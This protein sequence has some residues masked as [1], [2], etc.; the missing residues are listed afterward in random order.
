VTL[1]DDTDKI[2]LRGGLGIDFDTEDNR[3]L[4]TQDSPEYEQLLELLQG[5]SS[6]A[7]YHA[8][9]QKAVHSGFRLWDDARFESRP[10]VIDDLIGKQTV[11]TEYLARTSFLFLPTN[12]YD[13]TFRD[14]YLWYLDSL[15]G[16][17]RRVRETS[18]ETLYPRIE[19][20][21]FGEGTVLGVYVSMLYENN[22]IFFRE[23]GGDGRLLTDDEVS[24]GYTGPL[25]WEYNGVIHLEDG[26]GLRHIH[27]SYSSYLPGDSVIQR[28]V[29]EFGLSEDVSDDEILD[30]PN[31]ETADFDE[32]W[33]E[34]SKMRREAQAE[35]DAYY[36]RFETVFIRRESDTEL[37][38]PESFNLTTE[39]YYEK[40][41]LYSELVQAIYTNV[42]ESEVDYIDSFLQ[43]VSDMWTGESV[44]AMKRAVR[45][46]NTYHISAIHDYLRM[47]EYSLEADNTAGPYTR[48]GNFLF[49]TRSGHCAMYA[50][51]M[52]L[53][54]RRLGL[55]ARYVT[56]IVTVAGDGKVQE[57]SER[58]FHAWVEVYFEGLGWIPFDPTGGAH[59]AEAPVMEDPFFP[60]HPPETSP[61]PVP[62]HS[63]SPTASA[64][65]GTTASSEDEPEPFNP[66]V[67]I[68]PAILLVLLTIAVAITNALKSLTAAESAKLKRLKTAQDSQTAAEMYRFMFRLLAAEGV[69][70]LV[71]ESPLAFGARTDEALELSGVKLGEIMP[72]FVK[73]EFADDETVVLSETEYN[74]LYEYVA[75]LYER[76]VSSKKNPERL[77]KRMKFGK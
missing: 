15:I 37:V 46:G 13:L 38:F 67:L 43:E 25:P 47:Y 16:P 11:E 24:A 29:D 1:E 20:R 68:V 69:M 18:F 30:S 40:S 62:T 14:D 74:S 58:D 7:E 55:P 71:G 57:M 2:Y 9:R 32:L 72:V 42:P 39:Q 26:T 63:V 49:D 41:A 50:S 64:E 70:R 31:W 56:G 77:K 17:R 52:T 8:F 28:F 5:Y 75:V 76:A 45:L 53:A 59:G 12:P 35:L 36:E 48:L 60:T 3:W 73:L 19:S 51:V 4:D 22:E 66:L 33:E 23:I 6:E 44:S 61:P 34:M 27:S 65:P 10:L 21:Y 54:V